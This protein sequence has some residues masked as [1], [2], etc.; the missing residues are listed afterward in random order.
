M[1][2]SALAAAAGMALAAGPALALPDP[3]DLFYSP[4]DPT[5]EIY[6]SIIIHYGF[7]PRYYFPKK[8][9][10]TEQEV[11]DQ[12]NAPREPFGGG[13]YVEQKVIS[14]PSHPIP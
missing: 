13:V 7:D 8:P 10:P 2:F 9:L 14:A 5:G 11:L 3:K 1:N 6:E 4:L 12:L